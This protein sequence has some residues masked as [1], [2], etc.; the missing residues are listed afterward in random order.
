MDDTTITTDASANVQADPNSQVGLNLSDIQNSIEMIDAGV[1]A[2]AFKDWGLIGRAFATRERMA[3]FLN[4]AAAAQQAVADATPTDETTTTDTA[5]A[6]TDVPAVPEVP[7]EPVPAVPVEPVHSDPVPA[8]P[9]EPVHTDPVP[10]EPVVEASAPVAAPVEA[11]PPVAPPM[12]VAP[13]AT[14]APAPVSHEG[15]GWAQPNHNQ[16]PVLDT[17]APEPVVT[18][19]AEVPATTGPVP[20]G[21]ISPQ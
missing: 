8:V 20:A 16:L 18:A 6:S 3:Q 15:F 13:E 21:T 2:G 10:A 7:V 5:V 19:P 1:A 9:V 12:F 17:A 14:P 4:A 11:A